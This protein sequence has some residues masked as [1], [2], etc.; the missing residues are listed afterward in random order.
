MG[1]CYIIVCYLL[2]KSYQ[3]AYYISSEVIIMARTATVFARVE[4]EVKKQ[5]EI[6]LERLGIPMSN[7]VDMFLRQVV[8]QR[9]IPF[10]M[11][12]PANRPLILDELSKEQLDEELEKGIED[13]E[14]G[15]VYSAEEVESELR[16][17]VNR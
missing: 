8:I 16:K 12:L 10:E 7:A 13:I 17:M 4:P 9:G 14:Q 2:A 1:L 11:K 15:R 3:F 6:V 5:A